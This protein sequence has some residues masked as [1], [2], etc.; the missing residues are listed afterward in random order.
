[1]TIILPKTGRNTKE[2][3]RLE[4]SNPRVTEHGSSCNLI[5]VRTVRP[6][7]AKNER[8]HD[9]PSRFDS[10]ERRDRILPNWEQVV[11]RC[12][13]HPL[14]SQNRKQVDWGQSIF[15]KGGD[16][17]QAKWPA[18]KFFN[19]TSAVYLL[20]KETAIYISLPNAS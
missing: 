19:F 12:E 8:G 18:V 4:K 20:A 7:R 13:K 15:M 2:R 16:D 6:K 10:V 9:P 17:K 3:C 5:G 14:K 1:M 11:S